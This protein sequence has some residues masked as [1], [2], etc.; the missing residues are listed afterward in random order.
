[1][2]DFCFS[3]RE[4]FKLD[5]FQE[6]RDFMTFLLSAECQKLFKVIATSVKECMN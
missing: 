2:E 4:S 1:M 5:G 3:H 6:G